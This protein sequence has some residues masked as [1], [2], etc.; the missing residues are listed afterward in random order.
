MT[1][2]EALKHPWIKQDK[3]HKHADDT[4]S[5]LMGGDYLIFL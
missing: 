4:T 3:S 2:D 5:E 1:V